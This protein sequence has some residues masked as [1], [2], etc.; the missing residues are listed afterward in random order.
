MAWWRWIGSAFLVGCASAASAKD[1]EPCPKNLICASAPETVGGAMIRAGYQGLIDT[2][3]EGDPMIVS[4][5]AGYKFSILFYDCEAHRQC[6]SLQFSM[7][8]TP[9]KPRDLAFVNKWNSE[10]RLAQMALTKDGDLRLTHDMTTIGGVTHANFS[11]TVE[12]WSSVLGNINAFLTANPS[13]APADATAPAGT[14]AK[15]S[16]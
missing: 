1:G 10:K 8:V 5:A 13:A 6:A 16:S 3:N 15:R 7:R 9:S 4:A 2:D 11:D 14:T 12:W